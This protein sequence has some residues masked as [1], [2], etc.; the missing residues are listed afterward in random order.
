MFKLGSWKLFSIAI[1]K[2]APSSSK[3]I[4]TVV[5]VGRPKVLKILIK[6]MSVTTAVRQIVITSWKVK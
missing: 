1:Q 6:M 2:A 4:D 5:E 3:T